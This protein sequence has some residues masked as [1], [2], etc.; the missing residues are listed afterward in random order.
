MAISTPV[1]VKL[2]EVVHLDCLPS[3]EPGGDHQIS[4]AQRSIPE[5]EA[6][7]ASRKSILQAN[8]SVVLCVNLHFGIKFLC[9]AELF[10]FHLMSR[11]TACRSSR[12]KH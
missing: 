8:P 1:C 6:A 3:G 4:M 10:N 12:D 5:V 11:T 2:V 9:L 7:G